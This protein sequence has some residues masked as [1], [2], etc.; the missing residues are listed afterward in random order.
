[1]IIN[2]T[3][4]KLKIKKALERIQ[5]DTVI[6]E[7]MTLSDIF[8]RVLNRVFKMYK[9]EY[10]PELINRV[11]EELT[12]SE[13]FCAS[14]YVARL[15]NILSGYPEIDIQISEPQIEDIS[16]D[17]R[18]IIQNEISTYSPSSKDELE[19]GMIGIT[20][21]ERKP[22][23][24]FCKSRIVKWY[25]KI[26]DEYKAN[27]SKGGY[28]EFFEEEFKQAVY[29]ICGIRIN[30]KKGDSSVNILVEDTPEEKETKNC[31]IM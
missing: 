20:K 1:M 8:Q 30:I 13:G 7:N 12:E 19:N 17:L 9:Q 31:I 18:T 2:F 25:N 11:Y 24:N 14:G 28:N 15:L 16:I 26:V 23:V 5:N 10:F 27:A 21:E 6:Y 29:K 22:F 4:H 3:T